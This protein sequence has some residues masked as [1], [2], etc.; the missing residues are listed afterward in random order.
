ML[1]TFTV[2]DPEF[3]I[4][5]WLTFVALMHVYEIPVAE[6]LPCVHF[7]VCSVWVFKW[8]ITIIY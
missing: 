4:E 1:S 2:N 3:W 8:T 6:T 5:I 7:V